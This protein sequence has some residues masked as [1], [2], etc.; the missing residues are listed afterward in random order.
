MVRLPTLITGARQLAAAGIVAPHASSARP[1][2][3]AAPAPQATANHGMRGAVARHRGTTRAP[4]PRRGPW[5]RRAPP[6]PGA[7]APD[8]AGP[9]RRF[10][11]PL[12]PRRPVPAASA[13]STHAPAARNSSAMAWKFSMCG[14][15]ITGLAKNAGSRILCPPRRASVPPMKTTSATENRPLNSPM[16]SSSSTAGSASV[17]AAVQARAAQVANPG[18]LQFRRRRVETLRLA[19]RQ[20][21]QQVRMPRGEFLEG[22]DHGVVFVHVAGPRR[23]A[24]CWRRSTLCP[25]ARAPAKPAPGSRPPPRAPRNRT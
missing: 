11:Q 20:N 1:I 23:A 3:T 8:L 22:R 13:I 18:R 10:Q 15:A 25:A 17:S 4:R 14:P 9:L 16:V 2:A 21:Q 24:W 6:P 7:R 12:P 5:R 19:R